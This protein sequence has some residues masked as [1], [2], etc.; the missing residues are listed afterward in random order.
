MRL[1]NLFLVVLVLNS[2]GKV[3]LNGVDYTG[4]IPVDVITPAHLQIKVEADVNDNGSTLRLSARD[5]NT[6]F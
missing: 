1:L 6:F 3:E 4:L 2:C 5:I